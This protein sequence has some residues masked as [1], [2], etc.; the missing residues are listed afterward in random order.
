MKPARLPA[1]ASLAL[2][3]ASLVLLGTSLVGLGCSGGGDRARSESAALRFANQDPSVGYVGVTECRPCH[4]DI[5]TTF[6]QTGMGRSFYPMSPKRAV[7]DFKTHNE[8]VVETTDLRYRMTERDG[9]YY[10]R[11]FLLD[12]KGRE[13]AADERELEWV[14]GSNNHNRSYLVTLDERLFQAPI[15]WYPQAS[16]W[17]LCPGF[18]VKNDHFGRE[19]GSSC[20]FCHNAAM[21]PVAG[22]RNLF[23]KPIP[24]GIDC[25]RC[26]GPGALHVARWSDGNASSTGELDATIVNPRRLTSNERLHLCAQCHHADSKTTKRVQRPGLELPDYRPGQLLS[27]VAI[28]FSTVEKSQHEFGLSS[29]VDRLILSRCFKES[30]GKIEC[31]TCHNPHVT[32]YHEDRP[33]DLFRRKCLGCHATE[34]CL[35]D[36]ASRASTAGIPDDCVACHMRRGEPDDQRFTTFTDHWIRRR[37]DTEPGDHPGQEI[38]P[39]WPAD[40]A[41]MSPGEQAFYRGRAKFLVAEDRPQQVRNALWNGVID[42]FSQAIRHGHDTIDTRFYLGKTYAL[43]GRW[44]DAIAE[45]RRTLEKDA[46]NREAQ[47]ALGQALASKGEV[48]QARD[49][50]KKM[51]DDDPKD[52]KALAEYGRTVWTLGAPAEALDA[53]A[54][55]IEREPWT[56]G[57]HLNRAAVLASMGRFGEATDAARQAAVLDPESRDAWNFIANAAR[58]AG[59]ADEAREAARITERLAQAGAARRAGPRMGG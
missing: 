54:R 20:L 14:V 35:G 34:D 55:A 26:H 36:A 56:A 52:V 28:P 53:Y 18:E 39:V 46:A 30:G 41:S 23:E 49:V 44:D 21:N 40:L 37:I 47:F 2:L 42:E 5:A 51:L 59:R 22:E 10:Q 33:P 4:L 8:F 32:V 50:F 58:E 17:D 7:E 11:Q 3:G 19:I 43:Q 31:L 24:H 38:A 12:S 27:A 29:Q 16:R 6:A 13:I 9:K 48:A 25:E 45:L 57:L 1:F 15:C